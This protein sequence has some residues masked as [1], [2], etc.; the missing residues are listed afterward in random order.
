MMEEDGRLKNK[1]RGRKTEDRRLKKVTFTLSFI[2]VLLF[3]CQNVKKPEKPENLIPKEKMVNILSDLYI[4]N[5]ARNVNNK[6]IIKAG[7]QLDSLIYTKFEIDSLQFVES[8]AFYSSNLKVY[9]EMLT[10]VQ[11]KL[12]FLQK[13]KD[14][15]YKIAKREDSIQKAKTDSLNESV[16]K[17]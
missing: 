17:N 2:L 8:N 13:E 4:S 15:L 9:G 11:E 10:Q 6:R 5:A 16:S 12:K 14:S 1:D 3:S 7:I